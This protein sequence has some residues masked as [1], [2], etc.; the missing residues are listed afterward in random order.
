M[1]ILI[2]GVLLILFGVFAIYSVSIYESFQ[3]TLKLSSLWHLDDPSN[4]FYFFRQLKNLAISIL[5]AGIVYKIPLNFI[6]THKNKIFVWALIFQL[7]VF[8]PL[9][10]EFNW[11]RGWLY[12]MWIGTIQPAEFFKLAFVIF[13][14]WWFLK[15]KKML[16]N[17]QGFL[18][19]LVVIFLFFLIFL[20]I[21]DL[22][23]LLVLWPVS[24][25]MYWYIWGKIRYI[26]SFLVI[27]LVLGL[28][29][30]MQFDYVKD[31]IDYFVNPQID[32]TWRWIGW[33]SEQ[34]LIAIWWWGFWGNGY[35][36]WLQKFWYIPEAQS[37][38]VFAALSEEI[39]FFG[40]T[41]LLLLYFLLVYFFLKESCNIDDEYLKVLGIGIVSLI[42]IQAFVNIWVNTRMLPLTGLTLPFISFWWSALMV[43]FVELV[44]LY[45]IV[46]YKNRKFNKS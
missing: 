20:K 36:K 34:A 6:K 4:Y 10:T 40:N 17:I 32:E 38:F 35:W 14:S 24:L 44:L 1:R 8:T 27:W 26:L 21:P 43:N 37:D 18:W 23:T 7:L 9:G 5:V 29:V 42:F 25:I 46:N 13:L 15:K 22:W 2:V 28:T 12:L 19:F 41:I 3:I 33:Q 11:S 31:R 16:M 45:K 39:G 30:W